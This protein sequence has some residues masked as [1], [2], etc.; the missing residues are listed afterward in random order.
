MNWEKL[1][2]NLTPQ[3]KR[4]VRMMAEGYSRSAISKKLNITRVTLK[5]HL[6]E[7]YDK[8]EIHNERQ[9]AVWAWSH[10]LVK[11]VDDNKI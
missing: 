8:L 3:E 4:I 10:D 2:N 5:N 1:W 7:I 11:G 6:Y 9:L